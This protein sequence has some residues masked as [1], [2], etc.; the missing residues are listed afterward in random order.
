[1]K[2]GTLPQELAIITEVHRSVLHPLNMKTEIQYSNEPE[3]KLIMHTLITSRRGNYRI[4]MNTTHPATQLEMRQVLF[5]DRS[6]AGRLQIVQQFSH[7][8]S[9]TEPLFLEHLVTIDSQEK[10]MVFTASSPYMNLRHQGRLKLSENRSALSY[11]MQQDES[12]SRTIELAYNH[13]L[14]YAQLVAKYEPENFQVRYP[15]KLKRNLEAM[16]FKLRRFGL[17]KNYYY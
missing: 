17:E 11:E 14:P 3:R 12:P 16:L 1:M 7:S 8:R 15:I 13:Q 6:S 5:Y 4:E 9:D 10:E 2:S